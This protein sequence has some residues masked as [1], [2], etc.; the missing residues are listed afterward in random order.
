MQRRGTGWG[1]AGSDDDETID[2]KV[3]VLGDAGVGKTSLTMRF[4]EGEF[5]QQQPT[6]GAFY[7]TKKVVVG[8]VPIKLVIWDTAGQERFKSMAPIYYRNAGR[9]PHH[10][11]FLPKVVPKVKCYLEPTNW[12]EL[13]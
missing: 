5:K 2:F 1:E 9:F 8:G 6:V 11:F 3:V 7:S 12:A 10:P 4:V 13:S